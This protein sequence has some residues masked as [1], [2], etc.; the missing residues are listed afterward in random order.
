MIKQTPVTI[1][2]PIKA[3]ELGKIDKILTDIGSRVDQNEYFSFGRIETIHSAAFVIV[4]PDSDFGPSLVLDIN[5]DGSLDELLDELIARCALGLDRVYGACQGYPSQGC[6]V[7]SE[8]KAYLRAHSVPAAAYFVAFPGQTVPF[9]RNAVAVRSE[10]EA[11]LDQ[12]QE[13]LAPLGPDEIAR[14][15]RKHLQHSPRTVPK[16][17]ARAASAELDR[18]ARVNK[19]M[20]QAAA[21]VGGLLLSPF[22]LILLAL[23]R[24]R[25]IVEDR[26]QYPQPATDN[27]IF[28]VEDAFVQNHL[29][30]VGIVKKNPIRRFTI[31]AAVGIINIVWSKVFLGAGFGQVYTIH[32]A[33]G[34]FLDNGARFMLLTTYDGSFTDYLSDFADKAALYLNVGYSNVEGYPPVKW[35]VTGGTAH[36]QGYTLWTR[37]HMQYTP[38]FYSAYPNETVCNLIKD[39]TIRNSAVAESSGPSDARSFLRSL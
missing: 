2:T 14:R 18:T 17:D 11:F 38:V 36:L 6:S 5:C 22:L 31:R 35:L 29:A 37:Q 3:L 7:P 30:T 21:V 9:I 20:Y 4:R 8:V 25:E 28:G 19:I 15:I 39:V 33:R 23:I 26:A 1:V 13:V 34:V 12:N 32:F 27:R 24:W 16:A 10:I